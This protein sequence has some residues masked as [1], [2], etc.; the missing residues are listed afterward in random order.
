VLAAGAS[1]VGWG[2]ARFQERHS[3]TARVRRR[4]PR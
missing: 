4:F 3:P 2:S 1:A